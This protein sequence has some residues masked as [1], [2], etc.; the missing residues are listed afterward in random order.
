[1]LQRA[2]VGSRTGRLGPILKSAV[3][4]AALTSAVSA[5]GQAGTVAQE[6]PHTTIRSTSTL[7]IVPAMVRKAS[8][9]LLTGLRADD[10]QL[11]DNGIEQQASVDAVQGQ[12][13]AL[14]VIMQTGG[15]AAAQFQSYRT[16]NAMVNLMAGSSTHRVA[17][18]TF[19]SHPEEIWSFPPRVD[20]LKHAFKNPESGDHGAA[21][22]DALICGIGLLEHQPASFRRVILLLSQPRDDGS[23]TSPVE[24]LQRIGE[25]NTT[26]Y[27]LTFGHETNALKQHAD[28]RAE[29]SGSAILQ[30]ILPGGDVQA[31]S[32]R[33]DAALAAM[34]NN[35]A[36]LV[37]AVSGGEHSHLKNKDDLARTLSVLAND[38]ANSYTLTFRPHYSEPG[39]HWIGVHTTDKHRHV[40]VEARTLYWEKDAEE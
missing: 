19:D 37:A 6:D 13:I 31:T 8:G 32:H 39:F 21:I 29:N 36:A 24:V 12:P 3:L 30:D 16:L 11:T 18:V 15:P 40:T 10:F 22:L 25:S 17:L 28:R 23:K 26:I 27:S 20:G 1:M 4:L 7:V 5:S 34:H 2:P 9:D 35:T 33:L 14:V 38:F